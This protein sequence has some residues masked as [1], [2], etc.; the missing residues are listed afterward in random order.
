MNAI[1]SGV[2]F[3]GGEDQVALV[4]AVLV[5]DDDD[6]RAGGDVGD[7]ALDGVAVR[8]LRARSYGSPSRVLR[9]VLGRRSDACSHTRKPQTTRPP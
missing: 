2:A 8:T 1:S 4:L 6:G 7:G 9:A 3:G 5:V